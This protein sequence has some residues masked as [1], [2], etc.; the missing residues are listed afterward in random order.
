MDFFLFSELRSSHHGRK[1]KPES[2]RERGR[3]RGDEGSLLL[4]AGAEELVLFVLGLEAAVSEFRR[5]I[6]ELE[7]DFFELGALG[8]GEEGAAE[9]DASLL[10]ADDG[11]L[12]H[13]PVL[14]HFAVVGEAAEGGD[15]LLGEV[16][17]RGGGLGVAGLADAVDFLVHFRAMVVSV[18]AGSGDGERD[19]GRMPGADAG[20]LPEA[21]VGLAGEAGDAP[22][23]D[24]ALGAVAFGGAAAVDHFRRVEDRIHGNFLLEEGLRI[25]NLL[26]HGGAAVD[27]DFHEVGLLLPKLQLLH[28]RMRDQPHHGAVLGD[29]FELLVD[30]LARRFVLL[31]VL[32]HGLPLGLVP[33]LVEPALHFFRKETGP[34]GRQAPQTVRRLDVPDDP[35]SHHRRRFQDGHGLDDLLLVQLRPRPVDVAHHVGHPRLVAHE[36]RQVRRLRRVVTRKRPDAPVVV[37]RPLLRQES[38]RPVPRR[39]ELT[40]RHR[41][42]VCKRDE[43]SKK[44]SFLSAK[45]GG[46]L[47]PTKGKNPT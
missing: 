14:G 44:L 27:L 41:L 19:A 8:L 40:V 38:Q 33:V 10:A 43:R 20:D 25:L 15:G 30:V 29:A 23:R 45:G 12:E 11:S 16:G 35:D 13:E 2:P 3:R 36:R 9:G 17:F 32:G 34:D 47:D 42:S 28:L 1:P 22:A 26:R 24:D 4:L 31:G 39:L 46:F 7:V 6:D 18:L 37:L 5:G 21:A